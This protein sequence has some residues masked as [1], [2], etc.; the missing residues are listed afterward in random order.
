MGVTQ[1]W[2]GKGT[3]GQE[4]NPAVAQHQD[5]PHSSSVSSVQLL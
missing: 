5:V 1:D 2:F 3:G 4:D